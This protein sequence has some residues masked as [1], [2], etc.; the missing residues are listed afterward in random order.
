MAVTVEYPDV[1]VG[2]E[3]FLIP[4]KLVVIV[5]YLGTVVLG[6]CMPLPGDWDCRLRVAIF[7]PVTEAL[8]RFWADMV[9]KP[10]AL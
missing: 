8:G 7:V 10:M 4:D 9:W 1:P 3:P 6:A 5:L 2:L